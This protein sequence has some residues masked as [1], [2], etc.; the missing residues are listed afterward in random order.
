MAEEQ[1]MQAEEQETAGNAFVQGEYYVQKANVIASIE[2]AAGTFAVTALAT[3]EDDELKVVFQTVAGFGIDLVSGIH[4]IVAERAMQNNA[5][6][7]LPP[8]LPLELRDLTFGS[9]KTMLDRHGDALVHNFGDEILEK[10]NNQLISM[11]NSYQEELLFK[12]AADA[13]DG[14]HSFKDC[15]NPLP[16]SEYRELREFAGGIAT[17]MPGTSSVEADFSLINWHK[18]PNSKSMTD[19]SLES[20]LHSKQHTRL[21]ALASKLDV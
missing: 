12:A 8:V 11:K 16:A 9:L 2:N 19:F 3:I 6:E 5:A 14:V 15:W 7:E 21:A 17:V 10:I 18:N 13:Y 1:R 4:S 20:I